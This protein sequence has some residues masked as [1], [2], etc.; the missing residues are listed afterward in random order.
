MTRP[1]EIEDPAG[2]DEYEA[3]AHLAPAVQEIR[4]EGERVARALE[5]RT[6]WMVNSA[7]QGGGVAEMLPTVISLLRDLGIR[8]EW[9]VLESDRDEFFLLTK[10]IHNLIHDAGDPVLGRTDRELYEEVNRA[11]A[12][13][14]AHEVAPGDVVVVHD[15]QPM[16]LGPMIREEVDVRCVWR[17]HIGLDEST[18]RTGAAWEFLEPYAAGYDAAVFSAVDYVPPFFEERARIIRPSIDPLAN[19]NRE[20]HLHK[21]VGVLS[22]ASISRSPGPVLTPPYP[23]VALRVDREGDLVP[24]LSTGEDPELL[25]RPVITQISR[26]DRLKG[27][28][29]LLRAF[30]ALKEDAPRGPEGAGEDLRRRRLALVRMVLAGPDPSSIQDD[31]EALEVLKEIRGIYRALP[32]H[33]QDDVFVLALPMASRERNALMV[34]A[35]QRVS[36]LVV[37][38]SLR[39]GFGLTIAEA[40]WKRIPI[41][42]NSKAC[43]P[44]QQVRD[45]EDGRLI[46]DPEDV[47]ELRD[48]LLEVLADRREREAWGRSAQ[49]RVHDRFLVFRQV[50]DWAH[51]LAD[52]V[53]REGAAAG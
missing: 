49:R 24:A 16:P 14:M 50:W 26:W 19:K 39:E 3:V 42:S 18:P 8:T 17:C 35:L 48:A 28:A 52:L 11:N 43:G 4:S 33:V 44:R 6:V 31:P 40:M 7:S 34:N 12:R 23:E 22:N 30:A 1:I 15:P 29:P 46:A 32:R 25:S 2:L 38:N 37:Q 13:V 51:L 9:R 20:L 36:T 10:R 41:L 27:F 53:E 21:V 47:D 45:G 5:G